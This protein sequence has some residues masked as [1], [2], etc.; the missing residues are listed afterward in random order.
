MGLQIKTQI[1]SATKN[2]RPKVLFF[3]I[4]PIILTLIFMV[5]FKE[6]IN[7]LRIVGQ[8]D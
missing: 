2:F 8:M 7:L 4:I 6:K 3:S 1:L 5:F